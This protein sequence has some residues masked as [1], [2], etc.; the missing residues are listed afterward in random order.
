MTA[1]NPEPESRAHVVIVG[2]GIAG[3]AAALRLRSLD[4]SIL[5]TILEATPDTGGKIA[6]EVVSGCVVDGGAD[7]CIGRKLR[8][9][10]L[11]ES[12]H[13]ADRVV[14]VNP[15]GLS[16]LERRGGAL[17]P[18][19]THFTDELLTFREGMRELVDAA[20]AALDDVAVVTWARADSLAEVAPGWTVG[21]SS[22]CYH[23][24]AVVLAI[25]AN[26]AA[27]LLAGL[28]PLE[29]S[30]LKSLECPATTTVTMAWL[31]EDVPHSLDATGYLVVAPVDS[32]TA[33]TWTSAKIPTHAADGATVIRGYVRGSADGASAAVLHELRETLG[34]TRRPI[35]S[36]TYEWPAGIPVYSAA[37][38]A[39]VTTLE[40]ALESYP[41]LYL[42]GSAFHGVGIPDCILSGERA[43]EAALAHLS[44]HATTISN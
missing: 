41:G 36:R 15:N 2:A 13:L 38:A 20:C 7:V 40:Q 23:A 30:Q 33:C 35:F 10:K 5:I 25:P 8:S 26:A 31:D 18:A 42:A 14:P 39:N 16:T 32:V 27:D 28:A 37:H 44:N 6:G 34:I 22:S 43:A 1:V 4:R 19:A 29:S 11:F 3:L 12:L 9:T 24:D 21:T 17:V